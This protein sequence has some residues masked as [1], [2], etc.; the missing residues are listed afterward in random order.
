MTERTTLVSDKFLLSQEK[1]TKR[2]IPLLRNM[3]ELLYG[4]YIV[5]EDVA[6]HR[7]KA[8][9]AV[10]AMALGLGGPDLVSEWV[11]GN[12]KAEQCAWSWGED[13]YGPYDT[14]CGYTFTVEDG[15]PEENDMRFCC[16]C[17]RPLEEKR[18]VP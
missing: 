4:T 2:N 13:A 3:M 17:G 16:F 11:R 14:A 18:K 9:R 15:T 7:G 1:A 10:N 8:I 6:E 12:D 5:D